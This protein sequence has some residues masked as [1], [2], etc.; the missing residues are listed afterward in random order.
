MH[1]QVCLVGAPS[2]V[3]LTLAQQCAAPHLWGLALGYVHVNLCSTVRFTSLPTSLAGLLRT[4]SQVVGKVSPW[5]D[6]D[7]PNPTL[8]RDSEAA[9]A[10]ELAWAAHLSLQACLLPPPPQPL[11][12][13]NYARILNQVR[14]PARLRHLRANGC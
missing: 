4:H 10:Q 11:D 8:K 9:L 14:R 2:W 13:A 6:P 1:S 5:V 12:A 3:T 7:S